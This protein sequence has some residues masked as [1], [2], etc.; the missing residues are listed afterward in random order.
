MFPG[1]NP[2]EPG[3]QHA[4]AG[5]AHRR[6]SAPVE[7]SLGRCLPVLPAQAC[8]CPEL[9]VVP[10]GSG[11]NTSF[12]QPFLGQ[13]GGSIFH[14]DLLNRLQAKNSLQPGAL[15]VQ[16]RRKRGLRGRLAPVG[17][18]VL[19]LLGLVLPA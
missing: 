12:T 16:R 2:M 17:L 3:P 14:Q 4:T 5:P 11:L 8:T 7:A 1:P 9:D 10:R 15:R 13:H 19:G 18:V 6:P